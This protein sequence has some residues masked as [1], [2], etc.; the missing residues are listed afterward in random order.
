MYIIEKN[1]KRKHTVPCVPVSKISGYNNMGLLLTK[2]KKNTNTVPNFASL[3]K[4]KTPKKSPRKKI[5]NGTVKMNTP[6]SQKNKNREKF[7]HGGRTPQ[8]Q[9]KF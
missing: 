3:K 1:Q 8:K 4:I 2:P 7:L 9:L 6:Q 5:T